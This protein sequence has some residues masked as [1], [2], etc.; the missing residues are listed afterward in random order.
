MEVVHSKGPIN[1]RSMTFDVQVKQK[2]MK[3]KLSEGNLF[4]FLFLSQTSVNEKL[5]REGR[6]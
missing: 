2:M 5:G 6:Q 3:W 4:I 1:V